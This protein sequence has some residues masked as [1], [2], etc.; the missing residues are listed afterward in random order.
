MNLP[1]LNKMRKK[2]ADNNVKWRSKSVSKECE[3]VT[4]ITIS[5]SD[6]QQAVGDS[7]GIQ[8]RVNINEH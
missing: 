6:D 5:N 3:W 1:V 2:P 7:C 8:Q 4:S